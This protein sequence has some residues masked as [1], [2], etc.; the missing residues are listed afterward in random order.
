M[1]LS[2]IGNKN[3]GKSFILSKISN[4][5]IPIGNN[6]T[7]KGLSIIY[8]DYDEKN[9]ICLDTAGFEVPLCEDDKNF[10]FKIEDEKEEEKYEAEKK[11]DREISIKD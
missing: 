3:K 6:I 10:V 1:T 7:T 8:P 5:E 2:I 4:N 9:I 11:N